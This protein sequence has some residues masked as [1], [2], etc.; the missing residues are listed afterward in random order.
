VAAP[1][2]SARVTSQLGALLASATLELSATEI[3]ALDDAS[4][5]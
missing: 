4:A 2:A 3:A 5:A 1:L